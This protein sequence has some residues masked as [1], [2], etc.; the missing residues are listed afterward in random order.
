MERRQ[1]IKNG[2]IATAAIG[3]T[4]SLMS[5]VPSHNWENWEDYGSG[6]KVDN[7]FISRAISTV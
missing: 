1:F 3:I 7:R 6:P 4:P 5:W 2:L